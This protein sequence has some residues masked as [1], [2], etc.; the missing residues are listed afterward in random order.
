MIRIGFFLQNGNLG[1][2]DCS[3]FD[4]CNPGIGGT[5]FE[6][7]LVA[8]ELAR[9]Y[10]RECKVVVLSPSPLSLPPPSESRIVDNT[11]Q[12]LLRAAR[13]AGC[14]ILVLDAKLPLEW[15]R[16]E[17][18]PPSPRLVA[19]AHLDSDW[20]KYK[21]FAANESVVRVVCVGREQLDLVRDHDVY[22]KA[23][24][25]YNAYPLY[26]E[27]L[28]EMS[29]T[30]A[31]PEARGHRVAFVGSLTPSKG[32]HLVA[33]AWP[34]VL[35]EVPDS[36]LHVYGS[37]K[38]YDKNASLGPLGI[39]EKSFERRFAAPL[40]SQDGRIMSSVQFH[41]VLDGVELHKEL[42]KAKVG[43]INPNTDETFGLSAIDLQLAG[44]HLVVRRSPG[45][46]DTCGYSKFSYGRRS[47]LPRKIVAALEAEDG[48]FQK[49][50][51]KSVRER[52]GLQ[53]II[54][55]WRQLFMDVAA[56]APVRHEKG[57]VHPFYRMKWLRELNRH[58]RSVAP[59]LPPISRW[60]EI[61]PAIPK[62]VGACLSGRKGATA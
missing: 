42:L 43:V 9:Q 36:E 40:S 24:Y 26:A 10:P 11:P 50:S 19:W 27:D 29:A 1:D 59:F 47:D 34:E 17:D 13:E 28:P 30:N 38:L 61:M 48:P 51:I 8:T 52:F 54:P 18:V 22:R 7:L 2:V 16:P 35:A 15:F 23:T 6:F 33:D 53:T 31:G 37:G 21:A 5:E 49:T 12:S 46:M 62:K 14:D 41:G 60:R 20:R 25:I 58:V 3:R 57:L 44:C 56:N 55:Q 39:A 45:V 32:F 4:L